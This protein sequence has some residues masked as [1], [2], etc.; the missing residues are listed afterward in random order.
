MGNTNPTGS[1]P[2]VPFVIRDAVTLQDLSK[3]VKNA[4]PIGSLILLR[5]GWGRTES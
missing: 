3:L 4:D 5:K 1:I 2:N